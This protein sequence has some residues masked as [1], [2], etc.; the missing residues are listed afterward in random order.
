MHMKVKDPIDKKGK[1]TPIKDL[2]YAGP[3][4]AAYVVELEDGFYVFMSD[5]AVKC[6]SFGEAVGQAERRSGR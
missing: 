4:D 1:V 6:D 2:R 5:T 3:A